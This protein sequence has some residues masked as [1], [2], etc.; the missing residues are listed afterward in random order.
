MRRDTTGRDGTGRDGMGWDGMGWREVLG[1][2]PGPASCA[3]LAALIPPP[4]ML[5]C[6]PLQAT[7]RGER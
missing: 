3:E 7:V 4:Y 6:L 2:L 1:V 5:S